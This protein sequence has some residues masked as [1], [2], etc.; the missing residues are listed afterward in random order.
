MLLLML[1]QL[2]NGITLGTTYA[3]LALGYSM[4]FGI[5]SFINFSHGDV[6]VFGAYVAWYLFFHFKLPFILAFLIGISSAMLLGVIVEKIGF[7]PIRTAPR[8]AAL[9]VSYG[10]SFIV[11]TAIQIIWG[12]QARSMAVFRNVKYIYIGPIMIS[13]LQIGVALVSI[14]IMIF[15]I[16][17]VRKT[18]IGMAMR[19]IALDRSTASIMGVNVDRTISLTFAIGSGIGAISAILFGVSYSTIYPTMGTVIGNK[20]F[21]A[22]VLGGAGSIPGAVFGGLLMGIIE[23][24]AGAILGTK[25]R[26]AVSFVI[27][28]LV[29]LIRPSGLFLKEVSKE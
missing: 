26:E 12:T 17:L 1:Q 3:L 24:L 22:V 19:A 13:G 4:I 20:G 29:L 6:C 25:V 28:I 23:S 11:A 8:L 18:K 7:K 10:F 2:I 27:L 14:I 5:L 21:A 15:L 16:Y 9:I